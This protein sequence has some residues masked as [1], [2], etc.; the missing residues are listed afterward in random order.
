MRVPGVIFADEALIRSVD[1]K[2]PEPVANRQMLTH[3]ARAAFREVLP[4]AILPLLY[5]EPGPVRCRGSCARAG[6]GGAAKEIAM[7][8]SFDSMTVKDAIRTRCS[9]RAYA[10]VTVE[11]AAVHALLEAA[12]RAPTA[13]HEEP[14]QFLV[15]QDRGL[16]KSLSDRAKETLAAEAG[17][18]H[19]HGGAFDIVSQPGFN[20][21]YD[22]GTLIVV[23]ARA[24][25]R[26][27]VADCWLAAENLMLAAQAMG[28]GTCVIGFSVPVLNL[29]DVKAELGIPAGSTAVAPIIVGTPRGE[30][31]PGARKAPQVVAWRP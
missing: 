2:V 15:I 13:M 30:P 24:S 11:R 1:D 28:L 3:L 27:E 10:P 5:V 20:V 29:P 6:E 8:T 14:W 23:C 26:F 9:V 4:A 7:T 19:H 22:A 18:L 25:G 12:V 16:L 31:T 17:R 21:F